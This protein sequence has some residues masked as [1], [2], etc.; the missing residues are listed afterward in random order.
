MHLLFF[1]DLLLPSVFHSVLVLWHRWLLTLWA[2][3]L[4][5]PV[6]VCEVSV[7]YKFAPLVNHGHRDHELIHINPLHN[8]P[9]HIQTF[10]V[11]NDIILNNRLG[12]LPTHHRFQFFRNRWGSEGPLHEHL[13]VLFLRLSQHD[14]FRLILQLLPDL[15]FKVSWT[16]VLLTWF[17]IFLVSSAVEAS[18]Q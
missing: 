17:S 2:A 5:G 8:S 14:L 10:T 12:L 13:V 1:L 11:R 7:C 6:Q 9:Q 3:L 16:L 18:E 4:A 15:E